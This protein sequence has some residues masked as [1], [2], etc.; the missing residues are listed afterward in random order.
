MLL[1]GL[2]HG[3]NWTFVLW[4]GWHGAIL[5][6]ERLIGVNPNAPSPLFHRI[7][8]TTATLLAVMLGWVL[9]RSAHIGEALAFYKGMT[10][11]NGFSVSAAMYWQI[12]GI[13]LCAL[14]GGVALVFIQPFFARYRSHVMLSKES[15][16]IKSKLPVYLQV[17]A[18]GFFLIAVS[19]LLA[20][21][22]S[23]FLYFQF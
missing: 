6:I 3:A 23:P 19:R 8:A 1:G 11:L 14:T 7:I 12:K 4:G 17:C 2:W 10:G 9:F 22:Y 16:A 13:A 15:V 21:S 18:A 20:I 5:A